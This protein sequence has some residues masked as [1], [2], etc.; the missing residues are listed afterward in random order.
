VNANLNQAGG[1]PAATYFL[2]L[3]QKKVSKVKA[4]PEPAP[5]RG[6]LRYSR[7]K[8]AAEPAA[9]RSMVT[10]ALCRRSPLRQSSPTS[11]SLAPLLSA[12]NGG[13][14][15]PIVHGCRTGLVPVSNS[16]FANLCPGLRRGDTLRGTRVLTFSPLAPPSIAGA[17]GEVRERCLSRAGATTASGEFISRGELPSGPPRREAQGTP[18]ELSP[19]RGHWGRL[20]L[21]TF[22]GGARKVSCRR[23]TP[24]LLKAMTLYRHSG[25]QNEGQL[26][27]Q[28]SPP[29]RGRRMSQMSKRSPNRITIESKE[30]P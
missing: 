27:S 14:N 3:R 19:G 15:G 23:A 22:L 13:P 25:F 7:A 26:Q 16:K 28:R 5:L 1:C 4:T 10:K 6:S 17:A 8:A 29:A 30:S 24:G 2:L 21:L 18:A 9:R 20:L 12:V 11:P